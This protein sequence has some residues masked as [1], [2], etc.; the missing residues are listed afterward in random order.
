MSTRFVEAVIGVEV[1]EVSDQP[2]TGLEVF[3]SP[4]QLTALAAAIPGSEARLFL[5]HV[6]T[7]QGFSTVPFKPPPWIR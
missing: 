5:P 1:K 6:V 3:G 2:V 4:N 7:G